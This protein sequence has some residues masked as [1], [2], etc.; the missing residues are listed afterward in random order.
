MIHRRSQTRAPSPDLE[1]PTDWRD[2]A[3]CLGV[4]P[5]VFHPI[6]DSWTHHQADADIAKA[7]CRQ[8][9][10]VDECLEWAI[11][12]GDKY[13]IAGGLTPAERAALKRKGRRRPA[14]CGTPAGYYRHLREQSATCQKCREAMTAHKRAYRAAKQEAS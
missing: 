1:R 7:I 14:T 6:G 3:A 11:G 12:H 4:D 9:P 5:E 8:C 10:V 13:A 2:Q